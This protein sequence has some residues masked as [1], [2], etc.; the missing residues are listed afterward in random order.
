MPY[1]MQRRKENE[2]DEKTKEELHGAGDRR[3]LVMP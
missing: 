2:K 1:E 3:L